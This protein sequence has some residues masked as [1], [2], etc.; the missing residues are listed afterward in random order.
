MISSF[1]LL[2]LSTFFLYFSFPPPP[3]F[4]FKVLFQYEPSCFL[5]LRAIPHCEYPSLHSCPMSWVLRLL[6]K[7]KM[8][9]LPPSHSTHASGN[10]K[11]TVYHSP[12]EHYLEVWR[13]LVAMK[14]VHLVVSW[15]NFDKKW[16]RKGKRLMTTAEGCSWIL[17]LIPSS[18]FFLQPD[19][20]P[21]W[22]LESIVEHCK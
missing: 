5:C 1:P 21:L 7:C 13:F 17:T 8:A 18:M 10:I 15:L 9:T 3:Y 22:T 14:V 20:I 11:N 12:V 19:D 16:K 6:Y 4:S 2:S